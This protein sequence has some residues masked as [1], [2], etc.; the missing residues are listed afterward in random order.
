MSIAITELMG[1]EEEAGLPAVLQMGHL[2]PWKKLH[3][4]ALTSMQPSTSNKILQVLGFSLSAGVS[5]SFPSS[6]IKLSSFISVCIGSE[7]RAH[8]RKV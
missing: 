8:A 1:L 5:L 2:A 6:K 7:G 3:F 4:N